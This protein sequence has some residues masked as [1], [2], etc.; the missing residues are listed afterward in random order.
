[1]NKTILKI[2]NMHC[3]SCATNI[4][5]VLKKE[6]GIKSANVN[7]ASEK[8]YLKFDSSKINIAK[9]KKIIEKEMGEKI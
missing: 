6:G 2:L 8:L 7:F 5:N 1:M 9:I 4:E 3:A